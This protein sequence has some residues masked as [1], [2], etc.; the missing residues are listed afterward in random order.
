MINWLR[1]NIPLFSTI[2]APLERLKNKASKTLGNMWTDECQESFNLFKEIV[3]YGME[4][5]F[6]DFTLPFHLATDASDSGIG[7]FLWQEVNGEKKIIGCC[8]KSLKTSEAHYSATKRELLGIVYALKHFKCHL[9]GRHFTLYTDHKALVYLFTQKHTNSMI[10]GWFETLLDFNFSIVHIPGILNILPDGLSR[11]YPKK[12]WKHNE[13]IDSDIS[14]NAVEVNELDAFLEAKSGRRVPNRE[15]QMQ[16]IQQS[17]LAGHFGEKAVFDNLYFKERV[18]W[19]TIRR[20]ISDHINACVEC[21]KHNITQEG[22]HPLT[23]ITA[24][25]PMD[26]IAID[27]AEMELSVDGYKYFLIVVDVF[28]R[29]VFLRP[30]KNKKS[31]TLY[32][33]FCDFGLPKILQSDNGKEFVNNLVEE[34]LNVSRVDH[35]LSSPYNPRA[36]GAAERFVR[37]SKNLVTKLINNAITDWP[38]VLP[39]VQLQMNTKISSRHKSSP[40]ELFFGRAFNGFKNYENS[41]STPETSEELEARIKELHKVIYPAVAGIAD[42]NNLK[43]KNTFNKKHKIVA[44]FKLDSWVM[45][46]NVTKNSKSEPLMKD[47]LK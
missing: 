1:D 40:F 31:S 25:F 45:I 10:D 43:M 21:K 42:Y 30:L 12:I 28:T 36:N 38:E 46:K 34:L 37:T 24:T 27:L 16:L 19:S 17:H 9:W 33:L 2:A 3:G 20:D 29:M 26:H 22:F 8:S 14:I 15:E 5:S 39:D 11:L 35:R 32:S 6:P 7:G 41:E 18:F 47:H 23:T 13:P 4:L 44:P